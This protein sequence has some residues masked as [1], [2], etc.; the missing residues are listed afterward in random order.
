MEKI[1]FGL[2]IENDWPPVE[3]EG[4]WCER[5]DGNYRLENTPFFIEGL[6]FGDIFSAVPDVVNGQIFEF[7]VIEESG[8][9]VVWMLNNDRLDITKFSEE[10]ESLN[11]RIEGLPN[12]S[13]YS[14]DVPPT[15]NLEA[16]DMIISHWEAQGLHF[17]YPTWRIEE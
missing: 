2:D 1:L 8:H 14:I 12:F 15:I 11:C 9:S 16:F 3:T 17:A 4:V 5:L 7:D 6:A 10:I 13:H